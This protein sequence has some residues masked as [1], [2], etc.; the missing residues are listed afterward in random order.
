MYHVRTGRF[1]AP[2]PV[3]AGLFQPQAWNRYAYALNSPAVF[4]DETGMQAAFR[5]GTNECAADSRHWSCP[6]SGL[7]DWIDSSWGGGGGGWQGQAGGTGRTIDPRGS[8]G[9]VIGPVPQPTIGPAPAPVEPITPVDPPTC[10]G[11]GGGIIAGYGGGVEAG[12]TLVSFSGQANGGFGMFYDGGSGFSDGT[13]FTGAL[14]Y[15][16]GPAGQGLPKPQGRNLV[17]G[18][19]AGA[20][21]F[22]AITN[23]HSMRQV[24]GPFTTY[25]LNV[26]VGSTKGSI[27]LSTGGGKWVLALS[28]G[29]LAPGVG[30]SISR[31]TTYTST[32]SSPGCQ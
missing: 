27:Q 11:G 10:S 1:S 7:W 3:Y 29:A 12:N 4:T 31:V 18:A 17:M 15:Q 25:S 14:A 16:V 21:P 30:L 26:G 9:V 28:G 13:Q 22:V 2:D 6:S 19:Y 23:A 20:G 5:S 8:R 24:G 32:D